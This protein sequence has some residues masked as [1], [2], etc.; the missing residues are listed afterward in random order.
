MDVVQGHQARDGGDIADETAELMIVAGHAQVD[1]QFSVELPLLFL[2]GMEQ[3]FLQAGIQP[4]LRQI[5]QQS[6][7]LGR[8]GQSTQHRAERTLDFGDLLPVALKVRGPQ[9]TLLK[10]YP[11]VD[12]LTLRRPQPRILRIDRQHTNA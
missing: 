11:Q 5:R 9:L 7:Y 2:H 10:A 6:R 3:S 8:G 12:F 1:G 4:C